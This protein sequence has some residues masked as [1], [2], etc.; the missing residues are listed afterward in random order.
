M[1]DVQLFGSYSQVSAAQRFAVEMAT[2]RVAM[3]D[4]LLSELRNDLRSELKL[5]PV[6]TKVTYLRISDDEASRT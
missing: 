2:N 3:L 4:D 6:K 5:E 1:A